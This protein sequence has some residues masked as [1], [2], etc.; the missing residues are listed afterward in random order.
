MA[1]QKDKIN[2][3]IEILTAAKLKPVRIVPDFVALFNL[4]EGTKHDFISNTDR[5]S[6]MV[7]DIGSEA[8]KVFV[9]KDGEIKMQRLAPV[10]GNDLNDVIQRLQNM[11]YDE[12]ETY[13]YNLELKEDTPD[14]EKEAIFNEVGELIDELNSQIKRSIDYYKMQEGIMAID[15]MII[16]GGS[17]LLKGYK[18]ILE[19]K[20]GVVVHRFPT[21]RLLVKK[22]NNIN[23]VEA[24][25]CRYDTAIGNIIEEVSK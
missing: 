4:L 20:L 12:A 13:K 5:T 16:S 24:N 2:T 3:L 23:E 14:E 25:L 18:D 8:T 15:E 6:L 19:K 21:S 1:V 11:E 7:V 9:N 17:T 22:L 10:G